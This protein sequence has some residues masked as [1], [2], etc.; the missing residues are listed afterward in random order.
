MVLLEKFTEFTQKNPRAALNLAVVMALIWIAGIAVSLVTFF[1]NRDEARTEASIIQLKAD[2]IELKK[3]NRELVFKNEKLDNTID[4][5]GR[6]HLL[7]EIHNK[8]SINTVISAINKKLEAKL[9]QAGRE[10]ESQSEAAE[11]NA[12]LSTRLNKKSKDLLKKQTQEE[13]EN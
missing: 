9:N 3:E 12:R 6:A 1:F 7:Q 13:N 10:I 11:R 4:S 5:M 2:I 8:D